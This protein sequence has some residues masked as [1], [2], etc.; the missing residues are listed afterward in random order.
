MTVLIAW[1]CDSTLDVNNGSIPVSRL[2]E[3]NI[4][5]YIQVVIVSPSSFCSNL[6]FPRFVTGNSRL[7]NLLMA[8]LAYPSLINIYV[9]DNDGDD[10]NAK[11]AGFVYVHPNDFHFPL[12]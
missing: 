9:S 6:P 2:Y 3:I 7:E 10:K 4:P 1:D 5:P 8:S 11:N 12:K